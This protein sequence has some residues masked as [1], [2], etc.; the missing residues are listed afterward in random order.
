MVL[1]AKASGQAQQ[2]HGR[3]IYPPH[4]HTGRSLGRG[5]GEEMG[6]RTAPPED[7]VNSCYCSR[8]RNNLLHYPFY[9]KICL[10][11]WPLT[12][13]FIGLDWHG[14]SLINVCSIK[15]S[16]RRKPHHLFYFLPC[17]F[18]SRSVSSLQ[19]CSVAFSNFILPLVTRPL[20]KEQSTYKY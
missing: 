17:F 9:L 8:E 19:K 14:S 12:Y 11:I 13:L 10:L 6:T 3:E 5:R 20:G 1:L 4:W 2:L 16:I 18:F 15:A 7:L